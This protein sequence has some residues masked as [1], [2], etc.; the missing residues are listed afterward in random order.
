ML[1]ALRYEKHPTHFSLDQALEVIEAVKPRQTFLTHL[2]HSF[3]HVRRRSSSRL[4]WP[5][6]MMGCKSSFK[7][8]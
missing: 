7:W 8:I 1:D 5:W 6:L 4:T 3:D 2:S